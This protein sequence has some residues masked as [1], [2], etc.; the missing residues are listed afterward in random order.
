MQESHKTLN[1]QMHLRDDTYKMNASLSWNPSFVLLVDN[2]SLP[3]EELFPV[4]NHILD[5]FSSD[6]KGHKTTLD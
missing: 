3:R 5:Y 6:K 1:T 2:D 4:L